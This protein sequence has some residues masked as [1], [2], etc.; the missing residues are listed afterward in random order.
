[1][2][3]L[4]QKIRRLG[5]QTSR[6]DIDGW[7]LD[8]HGNRVGTYETWKPMSLEE[9]TDPVIGI[10]H[11]VLGPAGS[12]ETAIVQ[13]W[14]EKRAYGWVSLK[15]L[16]ALLGERTVTSLLTTD[17]SKIAH[18][19]QPASPSVASMNPGWFK[20]M[21]WAAT[22]AEEVPWIP[23]W[24]L[25]W[26][27]GQSKDGTSAKG[28]CQNMKPSVPWKP[29]WDLATI[30]VLRGKGY[31]L[32][33]DTEVVYPTALIPPKTVFEVHE[34]VRATQRRMRQTPGMTPGNMTSTRR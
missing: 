22:R 20:Q 5:Q 18:E 10:T 31:D 21:L 12:E 4:P 15:R 24:D 6:K 17:I 19:A 2:L 9:L 8:T 27:V 1:M 13:A 23:Q 26:K 14:N 30:K 29:T 11:M 28:E 16:K 7:S 3:K 32:H 34:M 33:A 25:T